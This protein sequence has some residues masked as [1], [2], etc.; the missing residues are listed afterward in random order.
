MRKLRKQPTAFLNPW[1]Q[2]F[3]VGDRAY[4][5]VAGGYH[6][7][8]LVESRGQNKRDAGEL[9]PTCVKKNGYPRRAIKQGGV[10]YWED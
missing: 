9:T 2:G 6:I 5:F 7:Y 10:W 1:N 8:D 3:E 4:T